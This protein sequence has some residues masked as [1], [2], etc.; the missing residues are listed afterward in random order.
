MLPHQ[1]I[2]HLAQKIMHK[3]TTESHQYYEAYQQNNNNTTLSPLNEPKN[4]V[5]IPSHALLDIHTVL[6]TA[7]KNTTYSIIF[8]HQTN[9]VDIELY[10]HS[11][12]PKIITTQNPYNTIMRSINIPSITNGRWSPK[13][14]NI[15]DIIQSMNTYAPILFIHA[16]CN[17]HYTFHCVQR[18]ISIHPPQD[19]SMDIIVETHPNTNDIHITLH[20]NIP[21]EDPDIS[22]E[23]YQHH[24]HQYIVDNNIEPH[25]SY[26]LHRNHI[27]SFLHTCAQSQHLRIPRASQHAQ[28][29]TRKTLF[30]ISEH[31]SSDIINNIIY[32]HEAF[33]QHYTFARPISPQEYTLI[34]NQHKKEE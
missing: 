13:N 20:L 10:S 33:Y 2:H 32:A 24:R 23:H 12:A 15:Q 17:T 5:I 25:I 22:L 27:R 29:E 19:I 16:D 34:P 18:K 8:P 7:Q 4:R 1:Q 14:A 11:H 31:P 21:Q 9:N 26:Q 6:R 3:K 30:H 28:I